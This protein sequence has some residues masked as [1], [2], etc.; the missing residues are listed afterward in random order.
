MLPKKYRL[1]GKKDFEKVFKTGQG[2]HAKILGI[3]KYL[4]KE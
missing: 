3:W 1:T 4:F 2:W